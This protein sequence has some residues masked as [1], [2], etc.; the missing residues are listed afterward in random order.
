MKAGRMRE[1]APG[2]A[3]D[4]GGP[5]E[6]HMSNLTKA[7]V[8]QALKHPLR[9]KLLPVFIANRPLSPKEAAHLLEEPLSDVSYHVKVLVDYG[10]LVL[11]AQAQIRGALKSYYL[12]ND[13]TLNSTFV[14]EFFA[15]NPLMGPD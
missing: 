9:Q 14:K 13:E 11:R 10:F 1:D 4:H 7:E 5:S 3:G 8:A 2:A 12:P 15:R 6:Y